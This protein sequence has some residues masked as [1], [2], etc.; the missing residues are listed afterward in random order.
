MTWL[1]LILMLASSMP[2]FGQTVY[3]TW[4]ESSQSFVLDNLCG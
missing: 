3:L 4:Q 2:A 1:V